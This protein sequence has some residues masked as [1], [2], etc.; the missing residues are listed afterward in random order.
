MKEL[1]NTQVSTCLTPRQKDALEEYA[2]SLDQP[3]GTLVRR[4]I[5]D[6]VPYTFYRR[7][8]VPPGQLTIAG[9]E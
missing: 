6:A 7:K 2:R 4:L 9:T 1:L 3:T 8:P 5:V